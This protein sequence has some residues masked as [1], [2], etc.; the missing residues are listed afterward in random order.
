MKYLLI[1]I[2]A[3][4]FAQVL[5]TNPKFSDVCLAVYGT[6]NTN[7]LTLNQAF[8]AANSSSFDATYSTGKQSLL[9]FRN[10]G[11]STPTTS[12]SVAVSTAY[13]SQF[14]TNL[15]I[16]TVDMSL[17]CVTDNP[18]FGDILYTDAELTMPY[19]G[20]NYFR[21]GTYNR[22]L[23]IDNF[24]QIQQVSSCYGG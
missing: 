16:A 4:C 8:I 7:G 19:N 22:I 23:Q 20:S 10:Y 18:S 3:L 15:C 6:S 13:D 9:A 21:L 2:S 12:Y 11:A 24:G 14:N 17:Y 5:I 1:L